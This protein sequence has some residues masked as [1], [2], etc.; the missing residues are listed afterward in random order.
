MRYWHQRSGIKKQMLTSAGGWT[1][2][3]QVADLHDPV[4]VKSDLTFF[5]PL[6][7]L[8]GGGEQLAGKSVPLFLKILFSNKW[9]NRTSGK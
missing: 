6:I 9:R 5:S 7:L 3:R 8:A 4:V 2:D 1:E